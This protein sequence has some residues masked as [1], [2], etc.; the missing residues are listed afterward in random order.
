MSGL[1]TLKKAKGSAAGQYLGYALQPVRLFFHLL[2]CPS[3]SF[4]GLEYVDD[5]SVHVG[6]KVILAEQCKSALTGNPTSNWSVDF[7]KTIANWID[8]STSGL[9]TAEAR[10]S[11]CMSFPRKI[12]DSLG[13]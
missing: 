5:I 9:I 7:W 10:E 4:V 3:D 13:N 11:R 1:A 12:M 2:T 6:D 8:N